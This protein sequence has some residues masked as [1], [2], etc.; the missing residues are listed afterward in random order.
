MGADEAAELR[1]K[2]LVTAASAPGGRIRGQPPSRAT[3][4]KQG[5]REAVTLPAFLSP[6]PARNSARAVQLTML[7][8]PRR[9]ACGRELGK[10]PLRRQPRRLEKSPG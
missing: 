10:T 4:W 8:E 6:D 5:G 7:S 3:P 9:Q 2:R 1:G